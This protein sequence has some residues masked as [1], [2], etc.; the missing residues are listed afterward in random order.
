MALFDR[1]VACLSRVFALVIE[2]P[3]KVLQDPSDGL[4]QVKRAKVY[5]IDADVGRDDL[6]DHVGR[7]LDTI[8]LDSG[9]IRLDR[10]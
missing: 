7:Q 9:I 8:S 6:V 2:R 4:F 10:V 5:S 3:S 1:T